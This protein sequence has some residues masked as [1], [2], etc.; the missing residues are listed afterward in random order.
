MVQYKKLIKNSSLRMLTATRYEHLPAN[1]VARTSTL[2]RDS[3]PTPV[4][5]VNLTP[6]RYC[7]PYEKLIS[8]F[9]K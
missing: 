6:I 4:L 1:A 8:H 7:K 2:K 3:E 5:T 9:K